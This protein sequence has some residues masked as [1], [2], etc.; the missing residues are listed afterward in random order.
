ML[1]KLL[2]VGADG[3]LPGTVFIGCHPDACIQRQHTVL[4]RPEWID[5]QF[6]NL[7]QVYHHLRHFQQR[8]TEL[9]HVY[10]L[11]VSIAGEQSGYPGAADHLSCQIHV[12]RRQRHGAVLYHFDF[13]TTLT[14]QNYRSK[15]HVAENADDKF[16]RSRPP[17]HCL[18]AETLHFSTRPLFG[19]QGQ[20]I[21]GRLRNCLRGFQVECDAA[22]VRFMGDIL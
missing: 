13:R 11:P 17:R 7:R 15:D 8:Q 9:V 6:Q 20:H 18:N 5:I 21:F 1:L 12:Q 10:S 14:E 2:W 3:Q 16:M 19:D 4:V 22:Y